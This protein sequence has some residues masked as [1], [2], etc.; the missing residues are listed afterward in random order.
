MSDWKRV[1]E[2]REVPTQGDLPVHDTMMLLDGCDS[3]NGGMTGQ[4]FLGYIGAIKEAA[5]I[6]EQDSIYDVG[7]GSGAFLYPFYEAGHMVGGMDYS[8]PLVEFCR[9]AMEGCDFRVGE[10]VEL[11]EN[12]KYDFVVSSGVFHYFPNVVYA[13]AV[14]EKMIAKANKAVIVTDL[15]DAALKEEAERIRR[16][17]LPPGE[18][19]RRY[20]TL[21]H[22]Y[23]EKGL[24]SQIGAQYD[25]RV[26]IFSQ[27]MG[28]Y[29]HN[30]YRFNCLLDRRVDTRVL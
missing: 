10:A 3:F 8:Q 15:P 24:F 16:E 17:A 19:E 21:K 25:C 6:Q 11:D 18:Y 13:S 4:D 27:S 12:A 7:C 30:D 9:N 5:G 26:T 22:L 14:V 1:W 2:N 28:H 20:R 29:V 23:F